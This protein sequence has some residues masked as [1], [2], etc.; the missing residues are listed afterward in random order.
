MSNVTKIF[1]GKKLYPFSNNKYFTISIAI[2]MVDF[3]DKKFGIKNY[4]VFVEKIKT[5][6]EFKEE[7]L[8]KLRKYTKEEDKDIITSINGETFFFINYGKYNQEYTLRF[9]ENLCQL[10]TNLFFED[11]IDILGNKIKFREY[12]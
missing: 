2:D 4:T 3:M 10:N 6:N 8:S 11:Y 12:N 9:V 1:K 5:N 7:V